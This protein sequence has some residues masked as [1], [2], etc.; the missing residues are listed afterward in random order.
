MKDTMED[1]NKLI[2]TLLEKT[3]EYSKTSF[4]LIKL[5]I[6]DRITDVVSSLLPTA[7]IFFFIASCILFCSLGLSFWLGDILGKISYGLFAVAAAYGFIALFIRFVIYKW[8]KRI[9]GDSI[10]K[11]IF[12]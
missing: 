11:R 2:E 7:V 12:N 1:N 3:G 5:K 8:L 6:T 4:E 10:I 9:V